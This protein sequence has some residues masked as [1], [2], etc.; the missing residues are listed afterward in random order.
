MTNKGQKILVLAGG[1]HAHVYI[2]ARA[3]ELQKAGVRVILVSP[4]EYQYYSGMGPGL[5]SGIYQPAQ[6]RFDLRSLSERGCADFIKGAVKAVNPEEKS[7]TLEDGSGLSYDIVSFNVGGRVEIGKIS[8]AR[9][10]AR[11][12]KPISNLFKARNEILALARKKLNFAVVGGGPAGVEVAGNLWRLSKEGG[13]EGSITVIE[14]GERILGAFPQKASEYARSSLEKR[15]IR[16]VTGGRVK[17]IGKS[18][19]SLET[20]E[21]VPADFTFLATGV[22]VPPIFKNSGLSAGSSEGLEIDDFLRHP[23]YHEIFG[24]GD[25]VT[26]PGHPLPKVGVYAVRQAPVLYRNLFAALTGGELT[27]FRPQKKYLLILNLGDGTGLFVR[28]NLVA[29][30]EWA[31]WLKNRLDTSFMA[32]HRA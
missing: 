1:G 19:V 20:G 3:L 8:G 14:G 30:G 11:P 2:L 17:E 4:E 31:L 27:R 12:V 5:L 9:E 22:S 13:N 7:L 25:C 15:G 32:K 6:T 26:N 23:K 18:G 29:R 21:V 10:F 16:I 28:G 24:G